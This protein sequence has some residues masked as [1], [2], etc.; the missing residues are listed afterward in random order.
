LIDAADERL[1]MRFIVTNFELFDLI[2]AQAPH[3]MD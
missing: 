2:V 3:Q 1:P